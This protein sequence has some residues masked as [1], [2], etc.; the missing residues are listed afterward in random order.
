MRLLALPTGNAPSVQTV[1]TRVSEDCGERISV[2]GSTLLRSCGQKDEGAF[3][4]CEK[5]MGLW[6]P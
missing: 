6:T 2:R 3:P 4:L 5:G 1:G